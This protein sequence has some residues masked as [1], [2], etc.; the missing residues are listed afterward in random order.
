MF[1]L[2]ITYRSLDEIDALMSEHRAYLERHYREGV[3]LLSGR[4]VPRTGGFI[5]AA[6]DDLD[7]ITAITRTD[8]FVIAGAARYDIAQVTPT[9][10]SAHL[11]DGL[12][13]AGMDGMTVMRPAT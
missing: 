9:A 13:A 11:H 8:P 1:I 7:A 4:R 3:F 10:A 5:L 12:A 6:G 2:T